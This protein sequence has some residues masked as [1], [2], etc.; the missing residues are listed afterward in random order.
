MR[1]K[2]NK[3][4]VNKQVDNTYAHLQPQALEIE[5]AVLGA[6]MIDKNA[7]GIIEGILNPE[8]FY[9]PRNQM[10]FSTIL[11]LRNSEKRQKPVDVLTVT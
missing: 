8:D 7:Y 6:L 2:E 9:E 3:K 4:S 1:E 10:V 11:E 5:R